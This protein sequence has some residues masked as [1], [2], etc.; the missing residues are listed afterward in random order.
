MTKIPFRVSARTARL[1]GRENVANA[2][3]AIIE[4]V[5]NSYDADALKCIVYVDNKYHCAPATLTEEEYLKFSKQSELINL[6]YTAD[7]SGNYSLNI[8]SKKSIDNLNSFFSSLCHLYIIDNGSGMTEEVIQNHWM[9]IGTDNKSIQFKTKSGRIKTGEK[10]IGRFALDR[11]GKSCEIFT[12]SEQEK[13]GYLWTVNWSDFERPGLAIDQI[14]AELTIL[15]NIDIK[16]EINHLTNNFEPLSKILNEI[17]FHSGTIIKINLLTDEWDEQYVEKMF[18][19]LE[20]LV[21][22]K[23]IPIYSIYLFSSLQEN[24]YG[25]VSSEFCNDFDYKISAKHLDNES[26]T[27]VVEVERNELDIN[28]IEREYLDIF[29]LGKMREF[30][31]DFETLKGKKFTIETT[32]PKLIPGYKNIDEKNILDKIGEFSFTFYFLKNIISYEEKKYPYKPISAVSRKD[33]LDK[34]GGIKIFRDEFRIRPYGEGK[35]DWLGLGERAAQSPGGAGQKIGGYRIRP[36]QISGSIN[37]SRITNMSFQDKSG[38]EG[39]QE[40]DAFSLFKTILIGIIGLFESDRNYVM[41][42]FSQLD[43]TRNEEK[44]TKEKADE[45]AKKRLED[46]K[47]KEPVQKKFDDFDD[48]NSQDDSLETLTP[49]IK[50]P[51]EE[52]ESEADILA[53][54]YNLRKQE[55]K[56]IEDE[57]RLIRSLASSG[58]IV[59]TFA[60]ELKQ[61][62][63]HLGSRTLFLR[64]YLLELLEPSELK[65][66]PEYKNPYFLI[67][68][69]KDQDDRLN[70]WIKLSLFTL[71]KDRRRR[72]DI[73]INEYFEDF[74]RRWDNSLLDRLINLCLI[75]DVGK[76]SLKAFDID[77]DSIF[78][79]LVVNSIEAFK[80]RGSS[81]ERTIEINWKVAEGLLIILYGDTGCGLSEDYKDNP[82]IIFKAFETTKRDL[83]GNIIGT[84][85]GMWLVKNII[86]EYSGSLEIL[87]PENGFQLE[88]K[89]PLQKQKE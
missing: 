11:L 23:E 65:E 74:K 82:E 34:F 6:F 80:G 70:K 79:N 49:D 89:F 87:K 24:E 30:P 5:K 2:E 43:L 52:V 51:N 76:C 68:Q 59:A 66:L 15:K 45:I 39:I 7:L 86:D 73:D 77:L 17:D 22:P 60:H 33:W 28:L 32:L 75:S 53:E 19:S 13:D 46:K 40:N 1:I 29:K 78:S 38:R 83:H 67:D 41:Y 37:I 56:E 20:I 50:K 69:M 8:V 88:I 71:R 64:K 54:G 62:R 25:E 61:L 12:F 36:N 81:K 84:G 47:N 58:L 14:G 4:L 42:S 55:L 10:G 18:R 35:D 57:L 26:K 16:S 3:G 21:P 72:R 63:I 48:A 9:T 44:R 31:Y 27:V 85:L